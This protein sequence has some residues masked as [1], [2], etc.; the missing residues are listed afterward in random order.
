MMGEAK[1]IVW[2]LVKTRERERG[3]NCLLLFPW[4]AV[5]HYVPLHSSPAGKI[6]GRVQGK[7]ENTDQLAERLIRLPLWIGMSD[8][9][10]ERIVEAL[11]LAIQSAS[12]VLR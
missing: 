5:F 12:A 3:Q 11:G 7:L 9:E 4:H 10:Q 1:V 2:L 6:F 8:S